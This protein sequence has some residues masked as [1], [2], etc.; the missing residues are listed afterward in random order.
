MKRHR[1]YKPL[2]NKQAANRGGRLAAAILL[3]RHIDYLKPVTGIACE[4]GAWWRSPP[5]FL[6]ECR[7]YASEVNLANR[8]A[9]RPRRAKASSAISSLESFRLAILPSLGW[10]PG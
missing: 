4:F 8:P 7:A 1:T 10:I 3:S 5:H 6:L 9:K 2:K